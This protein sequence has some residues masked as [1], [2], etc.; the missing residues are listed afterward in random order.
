MKKIWIICA[1][2]LAVSLSL[3]VLM[4]SC[5]QE[6][7][8]EKVSVTT[9]TRPTTVPVTYV[10]SDYVFLGT[11]MGMSLEETQAALNEPIEIRTSE[12]G[13]IFFATMKKGLEFVKE[14][15]EVAVYFI[16]DY[17]ARLCEVQYAPTGAKGY[18]LEK[19][20]DKLEGLY[21]RH[22]EVTSEDGKTN[23]VWFSN[24]DYIV[25]TRFADGQN[26]VSYF[27]K[28]YFESTQPEEAKAY[29]E[30]TGE[31]QDSQTQPVETTAAVSE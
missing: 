10:Y 29:K 25:V 11:R 17:Q 19:T 20:V 12:K 5:K 22:A 14:D 1:V 7:T 27:G 13:L 15:A 30:L 24:G 6:E 21:G 18:V 28:D 4:T 8:F 2:L 26:A 3:V 16:F 31:Q 9:T 23:Y